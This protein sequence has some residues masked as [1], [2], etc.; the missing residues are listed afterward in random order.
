MI[1]FDE[2]RAMPG[3][4]ELIDET[5]ALARNPPT[6]NIAGWLCGSYRFNNTISDLATV[7]KVP[8]S[9]IK[10]TA[11]AGLVEVFQAERGRQ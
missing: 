3:M 11:L 8:L 7:L 4:T 9:E 5:R 6:D 2:L 10:A 1:G